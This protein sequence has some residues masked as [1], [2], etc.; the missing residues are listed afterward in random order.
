MLWNKLKKKKYFSLDVHFAITTKSQYD[1][2]LYN[3]VDSI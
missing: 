1:T 2:V 3:N